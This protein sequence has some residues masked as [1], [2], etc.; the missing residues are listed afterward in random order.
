EWVCHIVANC[1]TWDNRNEKLPLWEGN[2]E[3]RL[4]TVIYALN[5]KVFSLQDG[6]LA[7][8]PQEQA[9]S[10]TVILPQEEIYGLHRN[11]NEITVEIRSTQ[12]E[13]RRTVQFHY[14]QSKLGQG[15]I[16]LD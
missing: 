10:G 3:N 2:R 5:N 12:T 14:V 1:L 11:G 4:S 6:L 9:K 15:V 7:F 16:K 8:G 13:E